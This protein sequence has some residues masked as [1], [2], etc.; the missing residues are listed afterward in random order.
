[1][2]RFDFFPLL[3]SVI[4]ADRLADL[5]DPAL[6][7]DSTLPAYP[8]YN[9]ERTGENSYRISMALAG[10]GPDEIDVAVE[11]TNLTV[12]G[13]PKEPDERRHY[14]HR[15]IAGRSFR[16]RFQLADYV[17]V[18]GARLEN[19]LLHIDLARELPEAKKP[20][21][22]AVQGAETAEAK[23]EKAAA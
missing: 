1:M 11:D 6:Q 8:P 15:G 19:G 14:I 17:C 5:L 21:R 10:F 12:A 13:K 22:I 16:R 7:T 3:R 9:I 4:G 20:R 18:T 2:T 23:T